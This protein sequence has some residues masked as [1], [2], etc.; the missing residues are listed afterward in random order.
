[1]IY[2]YIVYLSLGVDLSPEAIKTVFNQYEIEQSGD[3]LHLKPFDFKEDAVITCKIYTRKEMETADSFTDG[4]LGKV[5]NSA[6]QPIKRNWL[7]AQLYYSN[8]KVVFEVPKSIAHF[9]NF[10]HAMSIKK[11]CRSNYG[12]MRDHDGDLL[13]NAFVNEQGEVE[14]YSAVLYN[15]STPPD[16]TTKPTRTLYAH[17]R[18]ADA[19]FAAWPHHSKAFDD[20]YNLQ[21]KLAAKTAA[22]PRIVMAEQAFYDG[23][24]DLAIDYLK[25]IAPN[26]RTPKE[27]AILGMASYAQT[28]LNPNDVA[29]RQKAMEL[30][31]SVNGEG[32]ADWHYA[33]AYVLHITDPAKAAVH[34]QKTLDLGGGH[35]YNTSY[36]QRLVANR[37]EQVKRDQ[38]IQDE[39]VRNNSGR[40]ASKIPF[41]GFKHEDFWQDSEYAQGHYISPVQSDADFATRVADVKKRTGYKL[42][43]SYLHFMRQH[44]GGMPKLTFHA[45]SSPTNWS[46][47][48]ISV[49]G[50]YAVG[51]D[52]MYSLLGQYGTRFRIA[53]AN[54]PDIGIYI[55]DTPTAGHDMIA[56]DY[57]FCGPD[58]EPAV[59]HVAQ[60]DFFTITFIAKDF[61]TFIKGL[62]ENEEEE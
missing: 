34:A 48:G 16:S 22:I 6:L 27:A 25:P 21:K 32:N 50:F 46:D 43:A 55:A 19:I 29:G 38:H 60:E 62:Q 28:Y 10:E 41:N 11:L 30:I 3:E 18:I 54:Y 58:G 39:V 33:L 61:E 26:K 2:V 15:P 44:N 12:L 13:A 45:T 23:L 36:L 8:V 52:V 47:E 14:N 53:E 1:M 42:P 20:V 4:L 35:K 31:Q 37:L 56:L 24:Y 49:E 5:E 59:V 51:N 57:R 40:L 17:T 7:A 9:V